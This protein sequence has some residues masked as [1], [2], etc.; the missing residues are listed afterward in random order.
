MEAWRRHM[1]ASR[2][3]PKGDVS[4]LSD[5]AGTRR[6]NRAR[7]S[8]RPPAVTA[9]TKRS[10]CTSAAAIGALSKAALAIPTRPRPSELQ[11]A[12]RVIARMKAAGIIKNRGPP[13]K[14]NVVA[15][16]LALQLNEAFTDDNAAKRLFNVGVGTNVR[17]E[18][19]DGCTVHG[20]W[21][22]GKLNRLAAHENAARGAPVPLPYPPRTPPPA[23]VCSPSLIRR[24]SPIRAR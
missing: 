7:S 22:D 23:H 9:D 20:V 24:L 3:L 10:G 17:G 8:P 14:P 12:I 5:A 21:V 16:A 1:D 18:W 11:R 6:S 4:I 19:V 15:C 2:E 13:P